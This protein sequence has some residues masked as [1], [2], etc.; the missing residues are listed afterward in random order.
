MDGF[1][2]VRQIVAERGWPGIEESTSWGTPAIKC[3]CKLIL[4][5]REAG[6]FVLICEMNEKQLLMELDPTVY[7]ETDHYKNYPAVLVRDTVEPEALAD[8]IERTWQRLASKK[9][10]EAWAR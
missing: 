10:L 8:L 1:E 4:R 6:V 7:F 3:R 5:L 9:Q 2:M